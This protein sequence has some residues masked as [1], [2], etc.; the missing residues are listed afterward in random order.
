M[1]I[2]VTPKLIGS[3]ITGLLALI[4]VFNCFTSV[5]PRNVGVATQFGKPVA[6]FDN[7]LHFKAPWWRVHDMDGTIQNSVYSGNEG[8]IDVRLANNSMAGVD[9]SVQW[10]LKTEGALEAFVNYKD[11]SIDTIQSNVI[12]RN[13]R[14]SLNA[15]MGSYNPLS[16]ESLQ[17]ANGDS[18]DETILTK[19]EQAVLEDMRGRVDGQVEV[20]SVTI[21]LITFDSETQ[22]RINAYQQEVARTALAEQAVKTA[23]KEAEANRI[24]EQS[25]SDQTNTSKCLDIVKE[26]GM[27][28]LGCFPNSAGVV[29]SAD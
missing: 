15:Q 14:S 12:D 16:P 8:N 6:T 3:I 2:K 24:L 19:F 5:P 13:L 17:A 10:R 21:P 4:L 9:V 18:N 20:I 27:S 23:E 25:V 22:G 26:K 1:D 7:G 29:K 28:P 11:A